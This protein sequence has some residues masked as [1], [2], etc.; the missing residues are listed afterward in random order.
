MTDIDVV[1]DGLR[2]TLRKSKTDQEGDGR[3]VG[4]P[5]GTHRETRPVRSWLTWKET[6]GLMDGPAFL[7]MRRGGYH[8]TTQRM[9]DRA[10]AEVIKAR[11]AAAG[12]DPRVVSGHSLRSG[13]AT[14]AASAGAS[15]RSIMAQTGHRSP[16]SLT[17]YVREGKLF[18]ENAAAK[19]GLQDPTLLPTA[20]AVTGVAR[21]E[22]KNRCSIVRATCPDLGMGN[23]W[24]LPSLG[25]LPAE[26]PVA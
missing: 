5:Y 7:S 15:D 2:I 25:R 14:S 22:R 3:I 8:V 21:Q 20:G 9:P 23:V 4:L 6:A 11:A 26:H 12:L 19:V 16:A 17:P 18:D 13:F 24:I 1:E 10:I